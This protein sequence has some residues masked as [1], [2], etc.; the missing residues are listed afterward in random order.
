M[1]DI[2]PLWSTRSSAVTRYM[3]VPVPPVVS[4]LRYPEKSPKMFFRNNFAIVVKKKKKTS[5]MVERYFVGHVIFPTGFNSQ[6]PLTVFYYVH[7]FSRNIHTHTYWARWIELSAGFQQLSS[8][9]IQVK[10]NCVV[11]LAVILKSRPSTMKL[12]LIY[13]F[14]SKR[15]PNSQHSRFRR[16]KKSFCFAKTREVHTRCAPLQMYVIRYFTAYLSDKRFL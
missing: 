10:R 5:I 7:F 2:S 15:R 14:R 12:N 1:I 13:R 6:N 8:G 3:N 4:G 9:K 11:L 16:G